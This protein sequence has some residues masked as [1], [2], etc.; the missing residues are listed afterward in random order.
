MNIN[1]EIKPFNNE[2]PSDFAER[3]GIA[4]SQ[5]CSDVHKKQLG[6]FFTP[7]TIARFMASYVRNVMKEIK[8]LDPGGGTGILS[9]AL[10]EELVNSEISPSKIH[11][12]IYEIDKN[13]FEYLD[14]VLIYLHIWLKNRNIIFNYTFHKSDFIYSHANTLENQNKNIEYYDYIISNPPYFKVQR[15]DARVKVTDSIIYGQ[16]NIYAM[17]LYTAATL[18]KKEGQLIFIT[19]R[20]FS[21]GL[22]FKLFRERFFSFMQLESV[23]VFQSRKDAFKRDEVLQENII[24][25]A[26]RSITNGSNPVIRISTSNG[27]SDINKKIVH[28]YLLNDLFD[29]TSH[30]KILHLPINQKEAEIVKMFKKW[31]GNLHKYGIQIST[32]PVVSFRVK[33]FI[34]S[35]PKPD[36]PLAPLYILYNVEKMKWI[37]PVQRREK[38]QYIHVCEQSKPSL[39]S[40]KNYIFLRRFSSKDDHSRLIA[41]PYFADSV[42]SDLIGI[43]NHLNYIYRPNGH[44]DRNEILG[45]TALLNSSLFDIYFRTFNGN[46]NV[47]ATEL[48]EMSLPP[49]DLIREIG[50]TIIIKNSFTM[51]VIEDII[52]QFIPYSKEYIKNE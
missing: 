26:K 3:L 19:P 23:H 14:S 52:E 40:N 6:Q 42:N 35:T 33:E 37:W 22:Y 50:D 51:D 21:S 29:R 46:I 49:L 11:L 16:S 38:E 24:L 30:Q 17:F 20:S 15:A 5:N 10:I 4:Y 43:E 48:R 2:N 45:L 31:K 13:L 8:I 12:N 32:G 9:C 27:L 18:L 47:S 44:L 39:V 36:I 41:T 34:Y 28:E 1:K 25:S 7:P